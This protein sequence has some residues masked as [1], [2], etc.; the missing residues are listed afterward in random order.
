MAPPAWPVPIQASRA[1]DPTYP[2]KTAFGKD[3]PCPT[4]SDPAL[5]LHQQS[6]DN[7]SQDSFAGPISQDLERVFLANNKKF[8]IPLSEL[9]NVSYSQESQD[10]PLTSGSIQHSPGD[11]EMFTLPGRRGA[12]KST[13]LRP[14]PHP[15]HGRVL[16]P[17]TPSNSGSSQSQP[18]Q[19]LEDSI[20]SNVL[21]HRQP[22][23][24]EYDDPMGD[25]DMDT[26][27]EPSTEE[28][29][30]EPSSS[31]ERLLAG[32]P[33][34]VE[35]I[36]NAGY[37]ATQPSTQPDAFDDSTHVSPEDVLTG[38]RAE[39]GTESHR[40]IGSSSTDRREGRGPSDNPSAPSGHSSAPPRSIMSLVD[41]RKRWRF[42]KYEAKL[43][44]PSP[45]S[46]LPR[47]ADQ[48]QTIESETQPSIDSND[49][50][51]VRLSA[52][53][54]PRARHEIAWPVQQQLPPSHDNMEIVPDSEP[55]RV[56][57]DPHPLPSLLPPS[58]PSK[59]DTQDTE[60]T[61][62]VPASVIEDDEDDIPL[63]TLAG[64]ANPVKIPSRGKAK[65][66]TSATSARR[67][68][69][70][71]TSSPV[72][73][74]F[75]LH[76]EPHSLSNNSAQQK[77]IVKNQE[78]M[79]TK[80][81]TK[82]PL[83]DVSPPDAMDTEV[84]EG[85][86]IASG[87]TNVGPDQTEASLAPPGQSC[88]TSIVPSSIPEQDMCEA[89]P[90]A[91]VR[92]NAA[93]KKGGNK[94]KAKATSAKPVKPAARAA[95]VSRNTRP[96][97]T[98]AKKRMSS[99]ESESPDSGSSYDEADFISG[100]KREEEEATELADGDYSDPD[101]GGGV[102]PVS[103]KRKRANTRAN[104][105]KA[106][107]VQVQKRTTRATKTIDSLATS[108]KRQQVPSG[109]ATKVFAHWRSDNHYY[110]GYVESQVSETKYHIKFDDESQDNVELQR[111][112][113]NGL[114]E[115]DNVILISGGKKAKVVDV[116]CLETHSTVVVELDD[117]DGTT[118]KTVQVSNIMIAARTITSQ[119]RDR[120]LTAATI[121]PMHPT[122]SLTNTSSLS[123]L[124]LLSHGS[125]KVARSK[126]LS[127][128]GLAV[129]LTP[130]NGNWETDKGDLISTIKSHG[131]TV[132]DDWFSIIRM[133]GRFSHGHKRWMMQA[134][135]VTWAGEALQLDKIF[136][137]ADDVCQKPKYLIALALGIPCVSTE[138]LKLFVEPVRIC[139]FHREPFIDVSFRPGIRTGNRISSHK[140]VPQRLTRES[141]SMLIST[142]ATAQCICSTSWTIKSLQRSSRASQSCA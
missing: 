91:T 80:Q 108:T 66:P 128:I 24:M 140:A 136:L 15:N 83:S 101:N 62:S 129:T 113:L 137:L 74:V 79:Q 36:N 135:E 132:I 90:E 86:Q 133:D 93:S 131:G 41:P 69:E 73:K 33:D 12:N 126:A 34:P 8:D 46:V 76:S 141:H 117:G 57:Q 115:G 105:R 124:S 59:N 53:D 97:S 87:S 119:W 95:P 111:L 43:P 72:G 51:S 84:P 75:H 103:K 40:G 3:H 6:V 30:S 78:P 110:S 71:V 29:R 13:P 121:K 123:R 54:R 11:T 107:R 23:N 89:N 112:R 55:L 10:V 20:D 19:Q 56:E 116:D 26:R 60:T 142:G 106:P 14:H 28:C 85:N 2:I 5:P 114:R 58:S 82:M 49:R 65:A 37:E 77:K 70:M 9:A 104:S 17:A 21:A 44:G 120:M 7:F 127:G 50:E 38:Q 27:S 64:K 109:T 96:R 1:N 122:R 39:W 118:R 32:E 139:T 92:S 88:D 68:L 45:A 42:S 47:S 99:S 4:R 125:S 67:P 81:P 102:K 100:T 134:N 35:E 61:T 130:G 94:G 31:Y 18:S 52:G 138:W 16:V 98:S 48:D 63:A 25:A 22:M